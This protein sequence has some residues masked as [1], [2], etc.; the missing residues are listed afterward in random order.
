MIEASCFGRLIAKSLLEFLKRCMGKGNRF[1]SIAAE[2]RQEFLLQW[3]NEDP[4]G[5]RRVVVKQIGDLRNALLHGFGQRDLTT[6]RSGMRGVVDNHRVG[7][8]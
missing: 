4:R 5:C 6:E 2:R 3:S 8:D 1:D 7:F